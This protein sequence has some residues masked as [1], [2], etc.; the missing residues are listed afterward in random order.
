MVRQVYTGDM[1][2]GWES[3]SVEDQISEKEAE[4]QVSNKRKLTKLQVAQHDRR[5]GLMLSRAR[6][7]NDLESSHDA[8]YRALLERKLAHLDGELAA[9]DGKD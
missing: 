3:K 5:N 9:S 8:R 7:L 6:I 1:A 2:R 4:Q